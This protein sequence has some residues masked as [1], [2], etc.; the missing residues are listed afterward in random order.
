MITTKCQF[1]HH[2]IRPSVYK[3]NDSPRGQNLEQIWARIFAAVKSAMHSDMPD[4]VS[5]VSQSSRKPLI[6]PVFRYMATGEPLSTFGREDRFH[7]HDSSI[8][9]KSYFCH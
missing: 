2:A 3:T 1:A 4:D 7:L 8:A 9:G 5:I 6:L